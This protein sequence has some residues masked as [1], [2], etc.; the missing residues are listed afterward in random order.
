MSSQHGGT[1]T[2]KP[3][4][5]VAVFLKKLIPAN[6][7]E[8]YALKPI[9][10]KV[11]SE[12]NIRKGVIAFRNFLYTL[13][14]FL[15]S[16]GHLYAKPPKS[17]KSMDDYPFLHNVT[18]LL[19]DIGYHSKLAKSSNSLIIT[20]IPSCTAAADD[21]KKIKT[22]RISVSSL[23]ECLRF[24]T[25]CGFVFKGI[26]LEAKAFD[27]SKL[28]LLEVSY[29]N[30]PI[31]LIGLKAMSIADMELRK[32]RRYWN[33]NYFLRCDYRLMKAED[34]DIL[35]ILKD[36]LHPLPKKLQKFALNLHQR[37][38][39]MGMTCVINP[40]DVNF[41]YAQTALKSTSLSSKT[42]GSFAHIK[43]S[44][45]TL[46]SQHI[47]SRR[48]WGFSLSLK[49]GYCLIIRAKKTDMYADVIKEFPLSL[50]KIIARGYGC[51]RKLRN[52]RCQGGCQGIRIPLDDS[53]LNISSHIESWLDNEVMYL[54]KNK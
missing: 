29:P 42:E 52:E 1:V 22:P 11:A 35:D 38:T 25:L 37:Y 49:E 46:S 43:E 27:I 15:I 12:E 2:L 30:N 8:V 4:N 51:D 53:I 14:D 7:P 9:F 23:I 36:F 21:N 50:Q 45:R 13:C 54:R 34:T 33:D 24:L 16:D 41:A 40:R 19:V 44:W 17:P 39:V 18:N 47:Y 5:E 31:M 10:K 32:S 48:V 26:D 3:I 6:I 20:E 28:Q